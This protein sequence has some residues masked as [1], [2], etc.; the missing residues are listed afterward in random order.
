MIQK[1]GSMG[2]NYFNYLC[3]SEGINCNKS[4]EDMAG[5]DYILD[6]PFDNN[7]SSSDTA[8]GPI[9]CKV[10][11]KS[12][13]KDRKHSQVKLSNLLRF[14]K[15]PLPSFFVFIE[16]GESKTPQELFLVHFDNEL[17]EK[18]LACIRNAEQVKKKKSL[19]NSSMRIN[20]C[21]TH[22]IPYVSG[23][24]LKKAIEKFI[25][26]GM[27]DYSERK[28]KFTENV[29]IDFG[30]GIMKFKTVGK[31]SLIN[32][33]E[34]SLGYDKEIEIEDV[35]IS[36]ERFGIEL[37][38]PKHEVDKAFLK[39]SPNENF[40]DVVLEFRDNKYS[41]PINFPAKAY[42]PAIRD[43][44]HELMRMRISTVFFDLMIGVGDKASTYR[45]T[46]GKEQH[47]LYD[48]Y[49]QAKLFNWL[50]FEKKELFLD[51]QI[52][53]NRNISESLT[54]K[55]TKNEIHTHADAW[56]KE[57]ENIEKL[58]WIASRFGFDKT[59]KLTINE[60][61]ANRSKI[62]QFYHIYHIHLTDI[63][64]NFS[65][66]EEYE[67][68]DASKKHCTTYLFQMQLG[69]ML[70]VTIIT[71][72][73]IS[74]KIKDNDYQLVIEK[75]VIEKELI[76]DSD[77]LAFESYIKE[78]MNT[79]RKKYIKEGFLVIGNDSKLN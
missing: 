29:G 41:S 33:I 50:C 48:L 35:V 78:E 61:F 12:T 69:C 23:E 36:E 20:Y 27:A 15:T 24:E 30:L 13:T 39:I 22:K 18:S 67:N 73:G 43:L 7:K 34:A 68:Y 72:Q 21:D 44:P 38:T 54:I 74:K 2:E 77:K 26:N 49:N 62:N 51:I 57:M 32:I 56:K 60:T 40:M 14:C 28:I 31:N 70:I 8:K 52:K 64:F 59:L 42:F 65:L 45:L 37:A 10:Q 63:K 55:P 17:I 58:K 79:I 46:M 53:Q 19:N 25:P 1:V 5:W 9:E 3:G 4:S 16:F 75:R 11:I 6:F 66:I 76:C 71:L 47:Y